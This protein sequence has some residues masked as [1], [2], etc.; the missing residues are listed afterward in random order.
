MCDGLKDCSS[1]NADER[2]C[3]GIIGRDLAMNEQDILMCGHTLYPI[4]L[5]LS[6]K[7]VT[8]LKKMETLF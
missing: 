8:Q 6:Q 1:S 4:Q 2:V 7:T 5:W 3:A